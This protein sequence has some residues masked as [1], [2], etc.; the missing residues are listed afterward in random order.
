M[1]FVSLEFLIAVQW[2]FMLMMNVSDELW[3][4]LGKFDEL[5][6]EDDEFVHHVLEFFCVLIFL[7]WRENGI[8]VFDDVYRKWMV[9]ADFDWWVGFYS[10]HMYGLDQWGFD[11][12][13]TLVTN[14]CGP[15]RLWHVYI[16]DDLDKRGLNCKI[17][18]LKGLKRKLKGLECNFGH[19]GLRKKTKDKI[20]IKMVTWLNVKWND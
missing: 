15:L 19:L 4:F 9:V 2:W 20:G 13:H 11:M 17:T 14:F 7:W 12:W 18:K 1:V 16:I 5:G 6:F 3:W 8:S 10:W